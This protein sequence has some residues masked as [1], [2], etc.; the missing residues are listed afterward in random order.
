MSIKRMQA[1][2]KACIRFAFSKLLVTFAL[3]DACAVTDAAGTGPTNEKN[4]NDN[5]DKT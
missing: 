4:N 5:N 1:T 3:S 2:R